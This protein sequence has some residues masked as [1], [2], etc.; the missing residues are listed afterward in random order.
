MKPKTNLD[1]EARLQRAYQR[2]GTDKPACCLCGETNPHCLERHHI[3]WRRNG[4]EDSIICRN[5]HRKLSDAQKDHLSPLG[6]EPNVIERIGFLLLGLC[7]FL[8][9]LL[10]KLKEIAVYLLE[11]VAPGF[12]AENG[13][14]E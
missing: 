3:A 7:D 6:G 1:A 11:Q 13:A 8:Q 4:P 10:P 5:C 12:I 9:L 14:V 2:L